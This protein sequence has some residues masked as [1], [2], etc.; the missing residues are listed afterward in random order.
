MMESLLHC[1]AVAPP[2]LKSM[3]WLRVW[4]RLARGR[5]GV[6]V[7]NLGID[8]RLAWEVP[9]DAPVEAFG[10][11]LDQPAERGA[12]AALRA[13]ADVEIDLLDIGAHRGLYA[14][15]LA[16]DFRRVLAVE[17]DPELSASLRTNLARNDLS[18]VRVVEAAISDRLGVAS[19]YRNLDSS[20]MGSLEQDFAEGHRRDAI[21]VETLTIERLVETEGIDRFVVKIDV[22]GHGM[23]AVRGL[24][25]ALE[26]CEALIVEITANEVDAG[27]ARHLIRDRGLHGYYIVDR[28]LKPEPAGEVHYEPPF[29]NWLFCRLDP[30]ALE[31][32]VRAFGLTVEART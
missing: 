16:N 25:S 10:R 1:G 26:R 7:S 15:A 2:A 4:R 11:P 31:R 17:A 27:L 19:F 29:L 8:R 13:F 9:V 18:N 32:R 22:E 12:L 6:L 21:T 5:R 24:G 14:V 23:A 20:L 28:M 30:P 3:T